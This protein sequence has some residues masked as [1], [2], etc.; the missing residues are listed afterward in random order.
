MANIKPLA[1]MISELP[2]EPE[3]PFDFFISQRKI[4]AQTL[5]AYLI[6]SVAISFSLYQIFT[7]HFI[8]PRPHVH[9]SIHLAF[10][11]ILCFLI[12]P[13]GRKSFRDKLHWLFVL[14]VMLIALVIGIE[15]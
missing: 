2:P 10:A 9:R 14:D 1:T 6:A 13:L 11:L 12:F 8:Q 5:L 4:N 7:G 15:A 3:G